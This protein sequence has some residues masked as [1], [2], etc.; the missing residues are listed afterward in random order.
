MMM[1]TPHNLRSVLWPHW[2][3]PGLSS[4]KVSKRFTCIQCY[5]DDDFPF[6]NS[7]AFVFP[8]T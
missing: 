7:V 5:D 4:I 8:A 1:L 6:S 2:L 3:L